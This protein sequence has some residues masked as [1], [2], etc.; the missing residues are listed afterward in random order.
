M[1]YLLLL[2]CVFSVF[3]SLDAQT[4]NPDYDSVLA[5]KLNADDNGMKMYVMVILKT[6][7]YNLEKGAKRDSIFRG[8]RKNIGCLA[9]SGKLIIAGPFEENDKSYQGIYILNVKTIGE[10][11][12]L[13]QT[14]PAVSSG[15]LDA[16]LYQWYGSAALGEYL[17]VE[18]KI[19]RKRF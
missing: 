8:H 6:G 12:E 4:I 2:I 1:K 14:E 7:T 3:I 17:K 18:K 16:E 13:L 19:T 9:E 11:K 15:I 5:K 10:A